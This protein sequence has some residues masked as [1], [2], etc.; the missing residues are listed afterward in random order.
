MKQANFTD[1]VK[2]MD[3]FPNEKSEQSLGSGQ[4]AILRFIMS[5]K[6]RCYFFRNW[7]L[8]ARF[9]DMLYT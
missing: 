6:K 7:N 4:Y 9:L 3:V 1:G 8:S 5:S 2:K